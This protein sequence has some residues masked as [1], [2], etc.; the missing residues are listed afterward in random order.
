MALTQLE[1]LISQVRSDLEGYFQGRRSHLRVGLRWLLELVVMARTP[2]GLEN[3]IESGEVRGLRTHTRTLERYLQ[4][5]STIPE[6]LCARY[7]YKLSEPRSRSQYKVSSG[8]WAFIHRLAKE[9]GWELALNIPLIPYE[10]LPWHDSLEERFVDL[11]VVLDSLALE[12][13]L[14]SAM[15]G[16][17]SPRSRRRKGYEV[18]GINLGMMRDVPHKRQRTGTRKTRYI[19]VMRSQPQLSAEGQYEFVEPNPRSLDAILTVTQALYPQYQAV[20]HFHSHP[21][22]DLAEMERKE[23]WRFS[24]SDEEINQDFAQVMNEMHQRIAA[25]FIVGICR[26]GQSITRSHFHGR[27]NTIQ[28]SINGCRVIVAAYRSLGSGRLTESNIRLALSGMV[29]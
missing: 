14:I 9:I 12:G 4:E 13:M 5:K 17:L 18:Y 8:A 6:A 25:T 1:K 20:G 19:S 28:M 10:T 11:K 23:G 27:L 3:I 21:Y 22:D 24:S 26:S 2:E 29:S 7:H 16:Y 15:E